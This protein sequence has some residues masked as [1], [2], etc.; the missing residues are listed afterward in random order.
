MFKTLDEI[1]TSL[2]ADIRS[3]IGR[4]DTRIGTVMRDAILYPLATIQASLYAALEIVSNNQGVDTYSESEALDK[5]GS[6]FGI[7]RSAG[8]QSTGAVRVYLS[9]RPESTVVIPSGTS[10]YATVS[11]QSLT[12]TSSTEISMYSPSDPVQNEI[13]ADPNS[14]Y[15]G[16]YFS[17][18]QVYCNTSGVIGNVPAGAINSIEVSG[19]DGV[20]NPN[21][22]VNGADI[23]DDIDLS[24]VIKS[25]ARGNSGTVYGYKSSVDSS[26]P[27]LSDSEVIPFDDPDAIRNQSSSSLDIIVLSDSTAR[28]T[29]V[30]PAGTSLT[31]TYRPLTS[32]ISVTI[33]PSTAVTDYSVNI[34]N[35]S[36]YRRSTRDL[37]S[38]AIGSNV[39]FLSTD[40]MSV[41]YEYADDVYNIQSFL[42]SPENKILGSDVMVKLAIPVTVRVKFSMKVLPGYNFAT[43]KS[44]VITAVQAHF[45]GLLIG[46]GTQASDII[47]A[48]YTV[49]GVDYINTSTGSF[50]FYRIDS[51]GNDIYSNMDTLTATRGEHIVLADAVLVGEESNP[52]I[53]AI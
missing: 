3:A 20:D 33:L 10:L 51:S 34:D 13:E 35:S 5:I 31:P 36:I 6:N 14:P 21:D 22:F 11:G 29:E 30:F 53:V 42:D 16:M 49:E 38:I 48:A 12:F 41:E 8:S 52:L 39:S 47:S 45:D 9:V 28:V 24:N 15:Y 44:Q 25:T 23:Q 26:F 32:V 46:D 4:I 7:S 18:V 50:E 43:V 37:S 2:V 1:M 27:N 17:Q 19:I 40:S